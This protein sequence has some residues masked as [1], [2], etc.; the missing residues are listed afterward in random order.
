MV[1][2]NEIFIKK[3]KGVPD[4]ATLADTRSFDV[5]QID[6]SAVR[7][8][9]AF[10]SIEMVEAINLVGEELAKTSGTFSVLEN[11]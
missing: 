5:K 3:L 6:N 8:S 7:V 2:N 10:I 9:D 4:Y 1:E 11:L